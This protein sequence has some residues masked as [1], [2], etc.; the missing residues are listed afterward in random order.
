M[1]MRMSVRASKLIILAATVAMLQGS[2]FGGKAS[3]KAPRAKQGKT[4]SAP[5]GQKVK[6]KAAQNLAPRGTT[7]L[8]R[9]L[10]DRIDEVLAGKLFKRAANGLLV[11]DLKTG[12]TLYSYRAEEQLNPASNVK[13]VSTSTALDALGPDYRFRTRLLG[14]EPDQVG[15]VDGDLWLV[16]TWDFTLTTNDLVELAA[17]LAGGK[18]K[19]VTG[20]VVVGEDD[21]RET[22]LRPVVEITV[23]GAA[24]AGKLA[25]VSV[26]PDSAYFV[27][28][29][30]AVTQDL[31]PRRVLK[32]VPVAT[33]GK[34]KKFKK[35][36]VTVAAPAAID[37]KVRE[38]LDGSGATRVV[39]AISGKIR[40]GDRITIKKT[41]PKPGLFVAHT[42]RAELRRRGVV[43][44]GGVRR[45][46]Q[47]PEGLAELGVHESVPI[48]TLVARVNKPSN[49]YLADRVIEAAGAKLY[50]GPPDM[51]KGL[52]AMTEYLARMGVDAGSYRLDNGS[53][54]SYT[55][56]LSVS[57]IVALY[58]VVIKD[59][60]IATDF[61]SSLSVAGRDGTLRR[62]FAGHPSVGYFRGK[63]GTL[64]GVATLSG[65]V[66]VGDGHDIVFAVMSNGFPNTRKM[67]IR[68]GQAA[69]VDA[70]YHFLRKRAGTEETVAPATDE[71]PEE[72]GEGGDEEGESGDPPPEAVETTEENPSTA[73]TPIET[74]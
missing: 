50:G 29:N 61:V 8:E 58:G 69:M 24:E 28:E 56:H 36:Y 30:S 55:N 71:E 32:R 59:A 18:I 23:V 31:K 57:Q 1:M 72:G 10:Q 43:V 15:T 11:V 19:R 21:H 12:R 41:P 38:E 35:V 46:A 33:K 51:G 27:V 17:S 13:L 63:T 39:L 53:G 47:P 48:A 16:G 34:K 60:R 49:N 37:V 2:A 70:M 26:G 64:T 45:V 6:V 3:S 7:A 25:Q 4:A 9:E 73:P 74:P 66:S 40:P 65:I 54:L 52:R 14:T 62:R 42:V 22:P 67:Q 5:K 20:D 44:E 68:A